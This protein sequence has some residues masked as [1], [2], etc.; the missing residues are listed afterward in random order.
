M[1]I[2]A[3]DSPAGDGASSDAAVQAADRISEEFVTSVDAVPVDSAGESEAWNDAAYLADEK[4]RSLYGHDAFLARS[5]QAAKE[6][7]AAEVA[8]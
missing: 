3:V 6:T 4:F 8:P 7:L 5:I 1:A 2:G